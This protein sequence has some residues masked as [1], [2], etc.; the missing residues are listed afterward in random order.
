[1]NNAKKLM[2][3][4]GVVT[5]KKSKKEVKQMKYKY[6]IISGAVLVLL[7]IA[8]I[9][10]E[11]FKPKLMMT[12]NNEKLYRKDLMYDIYTAEMQGS[13]MDSI[14]K[15]INGTGYWDMRVNQNDSSDTT[16]YRDQTRKQ[17]QTTAKQREVL[18]QAAAEANV[19]LTADEKKKADEQ[20]ATV[21]KNMT[22]AQKGMSGLD[23]KTL[24]NVLEKSALAS[25]YRQ[26]LIDAYD[27]DDAALRKSVSKT[28]YR[29]YKLQTYFVSTK[30]TENNKSVDM[31][32]KEKELLLTQMKDLLKKGQSA[33]DFTKLVGTDDKSGIKYQEESF[34]ATDKTKDFLNEA[35]IKAVKGMKN[36]QISA[37]LTVEGGYAFV[38]MVNNNSTEAYEEQVKTVISNE[39][40]KRFN[41][42]YEDEILPEFDVVIN[43]QQWKASRLVIGSITI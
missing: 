27:I 2:K 42:Q 31:T 21:R 23:E 1:M 10:F 25:K 5:K 3:N 9:L 24:T 20:V 38:K 29:Q 40:T 43:Q 13:Q 32:A 34:I 28:D 18:C 35:N 19:S 6:M 4:Q 11:Q 39:E 37:V 15:Q 16:T 36:N 22:D 14:Y 12:I 7:I 30:K 26:Q 33:K 17:I 41:E 8:G